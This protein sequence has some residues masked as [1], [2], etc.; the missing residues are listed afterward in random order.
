MCSRLAGYLTQ[1]HPNVCVEIALFHDKR[2]YWIPETIPVHCLGSN[3]VK[4]FFRLNALK[5]KISANVV[6][7]FMP[8][9][10]FLCAISKNKN[11]VLVVSERISVKRYYTG[12]KG[13]IIKSGIRILYKKADWVVPVSDS[14]RVELETLGVNPKALVTIENPVDLA[15]L[16]KLATEGRY[17][18]D[19]TRYNL[20]SLGRLCPQKNFESLLVIFKSLITIQPTCNKGKPLHLT[21]QGDGPSLAELKKLATQLEL[22]N[23]VSFLPF[24]PNP[25]PFLKSADLFAM[26]SKAEGFPNALIESMALGIPSVSFNCPTGPK[27]LLE[28][29]D[30]LIEEGD[31]AG[32]VLALKNLITDEKE[33]A[34]HSV[35][36]LEQA[37]KRSHQ[38]I[39]KKFE[40][41]LGL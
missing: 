15:G 20:Y 9:S 3:P 5:K 21:I 31:L 16:E 11:E 12:V 17:R 39:F 28:G 22:N 18:L 30:Y 19:S 36:C 13:F 27:E 2:D 10:N 38:V 4:A 25:F 14:L 26:T 8:K 1:A 23:R 34:A 33:H 40:K 35:F 6:F 7:S 41:I 29:S 24:M 37:R 32:Y